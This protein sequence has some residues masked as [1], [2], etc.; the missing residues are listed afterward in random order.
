VERTY[1][2]L[3]NCVLKPAEI[4]QPVVVTREQAV[5]KPAPEGLLNLGFLDGRTGDGSQDHFFP[6]LWEAGDEA[7]LGKTKQGDEPLEAVP[8]VQQT[9]FEGELSE[10]GQNNSLARSSKK[11][12]GH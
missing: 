1:A 2:V 3:G 7:A 4:I 6:L 5:V 8:V 9:R 10:H 12:C 11:P